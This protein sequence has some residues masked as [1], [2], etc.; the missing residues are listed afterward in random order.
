MLRLCLLLAALPAFSEQP[1]LTREAVISHGP[2]PRGPA[3]DEILPGMMLC[4]DAIHG[5][6]ATTLVVLG[7][8]EAQAGKGVLRGVTLESSG[9]S[10]VEAA[11]AKCVVKE[12]GQ[13]VYPA[14]G[15]EGI[16]IRY[17]LH[18]R[19]DRPHK[20]DKR[21]V[22]RVKLPM[23][24]RAPFPKPMKPEDEEPAKPKAAQGLSQAAVKERESIRQLA[25]AALRPVVEAC[26]RKEG[27]SEVGSNRFVTLRFSIISVDGGKAGIEELSAG[28]SS[29]ASTP[30]RNCAVEKAQG[31]TFR[32]DPAKAKIIQP[33]GIETSSPF[34]APSS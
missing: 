23:P 14:P 12:L 8:I 7:R 19:T 4:R 27:A 25:I 1:F 20:K 11:L 17:R 26:F 15:Q 5:S 9:K 32:L 21:I 16:N 18:F 31:L 30:I 34:Q 6:L 33:E 28:V 10:P 29:T 13:A 2:A 24:E 3:I 22:T